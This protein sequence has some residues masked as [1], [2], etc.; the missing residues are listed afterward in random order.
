MSRSLKA[1][2]L[3][4]A[5]TF[6]WGV[7]FVEIKDAL[8]DVS[9]LLFNAVRMTLAGAA[10][11][12]VFRKHLRMT[13]AALG[14]GIWMGTLLWMGYEFQT[15]GLVLTT[16]S[17]SAFLTGVSVVLVPVFLA[18]LWRRH[19]NRW[20]SLG[21]LAAFVGLYLLTVPS[22]GPGGFF[23]GINKGDA[24]TLG[25]AV[26][27]AFQIIFMGRAMRSHAFE[28]I[29]TLQACVA[30]VLM[31][32]SVPLL[33]KPHV[34]WSPRVVIAILVTAL[35]GTAAAFTIQAWAQ[36]FT[37]PT[38]TALIFVLEPVF[39]WASSYVLLGER[40]GTR[41]GLGA[42]LIIAGVLLSELK[43]SASLPSGE[44]GDGARVAME[45]ETAR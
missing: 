5:V 11:A 44:V 40:L 14:T 12:L 19:I 23:S 10:L 27:F 39:A 8:G 28:Q 3:L 34:V 6:V 45:R 17:K 2:V 20:T 38:H 26:T 1:H 7:T 42:L 4:V 15:T 22:S 29:A 9:P 25:C 30:A 41:A 43:G 13:A 31:A 24:L 21:V 16:P 32:A 33:E 37:P 36:Q 35:L 18:L